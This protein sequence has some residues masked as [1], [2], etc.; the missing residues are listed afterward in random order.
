MIIRRGYK[1]TF[2]SPQNSFGKTIQ[3]ILQEHGAKPHPA[4][5]KGPNQYMDRYL[6][7]TGKAIAHE[8]GLKSVQ[9]IWVRAKDLPYVNLGEIPSKWYSSSQLSQRMPNGGIRYGRHSGLKTVPELR[10]ADL[11]R[12]SPRDDG[13]LLRILNAMQP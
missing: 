12:F 4:I 6:L 10:D 9:H 1:M 8:H 7:P 11:I 5:P 2:P 3:A 13:D